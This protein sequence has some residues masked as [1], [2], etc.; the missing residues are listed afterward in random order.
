MCIISC[1][2]RKQQDHETMRLATREF[3]SKNGSHFASHCHCQLLAARQRGQCRLP[4]ERGAQCRYRQCGQWKRLAPNAGVPQAASCQST[5]SLWALNLSR[6][7]RTGRKTRRMP[8]K[9]NSSW[10]ASLLLS[11]DGQSVS[12]SVRPGADWL[13]SFQCGAYCP[14]PPL[15][16]RSKGERTSASLR[17]VTWR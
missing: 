17:A 7:S 3:P 9:V 15:P 12:M 8:P 2:Q 10:T 5:R 4:Q 14:M 13:E 1:L 16:M 6:C 11:T